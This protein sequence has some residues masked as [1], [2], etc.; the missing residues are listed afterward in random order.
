MN[1]TEVMSTQWLHQGALPGWTIVGTGDFNGDGKTD[2]LWQDSAGRVA[3][4]FMDGTSVG[5]SQYIYDQPLPGWSVVA[6]K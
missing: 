4:W 2:I 5:A 3:V 6:S 1:G